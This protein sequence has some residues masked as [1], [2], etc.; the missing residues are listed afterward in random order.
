MTIALTV[1]G[2]P[3]GKGRPRFAVTR[4]FG[5][6]PVAHAF[7][8]KKTVNA[9]VQIRERFA[10]EYP[11]HVPFGG[12]VHLTVLAYF[13]IPASWPAKCKVAALKGETLPTKKP[14]I[15]NIIK[16]CGDALNALAYCDDVQVVSTTAKKAYAEVPRIE[17]I[18][19]EITP[20]EHA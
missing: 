11:G 9:E 10:A 4:Q 7:T 19:R 14:D 16:L 1:P 2:E 20:K 3:C 12:P 18:V 8:P 15:D 13:G 5:R 6:R 17:I